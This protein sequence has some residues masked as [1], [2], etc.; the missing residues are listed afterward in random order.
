MINPDKNQQVNCCQP[1]YNLLCLYEAV[2]NVCFQA[3]LS[4]KR[5]STLLIL[6]HIFIFSL[7]PPRIWPTPSS[8]SVGR[9]NHGDGLPGPQPEPCPPGWRQVAAERRGVGPNHGRLRGQGSE[10]V[11]P[12]RDQ[13]RTQLLV[14]QH[15]IWRRNRCQG[16]TERHNTDSNCSK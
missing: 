16:K 2:V 10:S 7:L 12:L 5:F 9:E 4:F 13:H 14:L 6:P 8:S 1:F 15:Q 11:P 3:K